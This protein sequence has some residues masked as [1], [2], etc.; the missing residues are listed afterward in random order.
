M[1]SEAQVAYEVARD[2][3][4]VESFSTYYEAVAHL[5]KIQPHSVSWASEHEGYTITEK[6]SSDGRW[7]DLAGV[8]YQHLVNYAPDEAIKAYTKFVGNEG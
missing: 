8:M 4:V 6:I 3:I 1:K 2:G 5:H 7:R